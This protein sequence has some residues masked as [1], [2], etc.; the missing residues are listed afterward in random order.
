MPSTKCIPGPYRFFFYSFDCVEQKHV[1]VQRD[2]MICKFWLETISLAKNS[3]FSPKELNVIRKLVI[4]HSQQ[5]TVA[6][7][8]HCG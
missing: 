2:I 7:H 8:E 5:I 3:G 6:W 1:H 4:S